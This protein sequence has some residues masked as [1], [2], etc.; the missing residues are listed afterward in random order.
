MNWTELLFEAVEIDDVELVQELLAHG[1]DVQAKVDGYD[2][3]SAAVLAPHKQN[4]NIEMIKLLLRAGANPNQSSEN[5]RTALYWAVY[6]NE[7]ELV[8]LLLNSGAIEA[9]HEDGY[10]SLH[11][12]A[13]SGN[14][15]IVELLLGAG[16]KSALN[17]FNEL[18]RT[19]LMLAVEKE[20]FEIARKLIEAGAD[21]NAF[22]EPRIGNTAL[23]EIADLGSYEMIELLVQEGADPTIPGWMGIS[24]LDLARRRV[25]KK[26]RKFSK[27]ENL[28]IL[29]LLEETAKNY[30]TSISQHST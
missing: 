29:A 28:K 24:A 3:L 27:E 6:G 9:Q 5:G 25:G 7:N 16:G 4:T 21:V 26:S 13:E 19:P 23:R 22:D 1:A 2:I 12:S 18:S 10:T 15:E 20:H 14:Q 8:R 17:K 11:A 30:T